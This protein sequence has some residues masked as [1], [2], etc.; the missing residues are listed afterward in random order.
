VARKEQ[1]ANLPLW[2]NRTVRCMSSRLILDFSDL[3][4]RILC[5]SA[6]L[7]ALPLHGSGLAVEASSLT[8]HWAL[9]NSAHI[10]DT[11]TDSIRIRIAAPGRE[12]QHQLVGA[13]GEEG[14]STTSTQTGH[15]SSTT[16]GS[17]GTKSGGNPI[18]NGQVAV[19]VTPEGIAVTRG[20]T[21]EIL[22]AGSVPTFQPASASG[23]GDGFFSINLT[24]HGKPDK[25]FGLGQLESQNQKRDCTDPTEVEL[26]H[27]APP[28]GAC[29]TPLDRRQMPGG[30]T[31]L[32]SVKYNI[33]T[34][35]M[36]SSS[37]FGLFLNQPGDGA[38]VLPR[39]TGDY[40]LSYIC[41]RQLDLWVTVGTASEVYMRYG[42]ATALPSPLPGYAARYW[43]SKDA[44]HTAD[45]VVE[46]ARN[47]SRRNLSVGVIVIDLGPPAMTA[48]VRNL[49]GSEVMPNLKPTS[50]K[51]ADCPGCGAGFETDGKADDGR[52]DPTSPACRE[53]IWAKRVKPQLFDNGVRAYWLDDD[54]A[55]DHFRPVGGNFTCGPA[56]YC[57]LWAAGSQWPR[58]FSDGTAAAGFP[59]V[60][61]SRN[62]WAGASGALW[63]SDIESSWTE[64]RAQVLAGLSSGLSGWPYWTSDV[65]GFWGAPTPELMARW[66]QFGSVCPLYRSHGSRPF[67]EPWSFGPD[68]ERSITKSI[69][70]REALHSYVLELSANTSVTGAP[71]IRPLWFDFPGSPQAWTVSDAFMLGPR[72]LAAPVLEEG[73]R[74]R[75]VWL[76]VVAGGWSL[77]STGETF[78]GGAAVTVAAPLDE[79]P[80][81]VRDPP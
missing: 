70:L 53:C 61:L 16:A 67:N 73:A 55:A 47:F 74:T 6:P 75:T 32:V 36:Y 45:E 62:L 25:V 28:S 34:G 13:L 59:S 35:F 65:G 5:D 63:S 10:V 26:G 24:L 15:T 68:A 78:A 72:Y 54:E 37:G 51:S 14:C 12:V 17:A 21:G 44:Y 60:V 11:G 27:G 42:Q 39:G 50:V 58:V 79:L 46:L 56:A 3:P 49:T 38:A 57:G 18:I 2:S 66:H 29:G 41:Q 23:C 48:T 7:L 80:L 69:Q 33:P 71:I 76:P 4:L 1:A 9:F 40:Q 31:S 77:Y 19:A 81:F 52:V 20:D 30:A 43:Q 22:L 8:Q 64:L